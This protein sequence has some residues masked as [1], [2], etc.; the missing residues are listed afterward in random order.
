MLSRY[1]SEISDAK[2]CLRHELSM[3]SKN[4]SCD[5][6]SIIAQQKA[7]ATAAYHSKLQ[8]LHALYKPSAAEY[9]ILASADYDLHSNGNT[10]AKCPR[11]G[12]EII[13][14]EIGA[15]YAVGCSNGCL[16]IVHR[17]I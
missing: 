3:I 4:V 12:S 10:A 17:G 6:E 2:S 15:S 16:E 11:C 9:A 1:W 7:S 14:E 13:L 5:N 8:D